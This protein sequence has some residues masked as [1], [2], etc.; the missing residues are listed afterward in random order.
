MEAGVHVDVNE[1]WICVIWY[2]KLEAWLRK[3]IVYE[4]HAIGNWMY[5]MKL[6]RADEKKKTKYFFVVDRK[7]A[8]IFLF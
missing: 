8:S 4:I 6:L 1:S 5:C 3:V 2:M 7:E